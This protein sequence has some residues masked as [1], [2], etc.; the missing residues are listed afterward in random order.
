MAVTGN[1]DGDDEMR[2]EIVIHD[3]QG[4]SRERE[5]RVVVVVLSLRSSN[6]RLQSRVPSH[7]IPPVSQTTIKLKAME[8]HLLFL[9]SSLTELCFGTT[10]TTDFF[11]G[12]ALSPVVY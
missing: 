12:P 11:A 5:P 7:P 8:E 10:R 3:G 2:M 6:K 4:E 1:G 9:F